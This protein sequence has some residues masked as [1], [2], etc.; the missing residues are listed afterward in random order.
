MSA[1]SE[2][3]NRAHNIMELVDILPNRPY[4]TADYL[5]SIDYLNCLNNLFKLNDPP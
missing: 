5:I 2:T 1:N 3:Y 4:H